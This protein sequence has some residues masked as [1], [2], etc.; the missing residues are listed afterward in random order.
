M[1]GKERLDCAAFRRDSLSKKS[2]LQSSPLTRL[3]FREY[4]ERTT[5]GGVVPFEWAFRCGFAIA[6]FL[7]AW[8]Y[9]QLATMQAQPDYEPNDEHGIRTRATKASSQAWH[10]AHV[11]AERPTKVGA[12][13]AVAGG[14]ATAL[15]LEFATTVI[16]SMGFLAIAFGVATYGKYL[17]HKAALHVLLNEDGLE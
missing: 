10:A 13:I 5:L 9:W 7:I 1:P 17:G 6:L 8:A 2:L 11:R 16:V 4:N 3:P 12:C 14:L 15:P